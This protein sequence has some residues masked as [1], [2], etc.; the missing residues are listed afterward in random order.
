MPFWIVVIREGELFY[1]SDVLCVYLCCVVL[2]VYFY[3]NFTLAMCIYAIL[4]V[5]R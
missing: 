3:S 1:V 2:S 5:S 4:L